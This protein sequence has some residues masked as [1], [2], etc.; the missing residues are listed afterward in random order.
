MDAPGHSIQVLAP[1]DPSGME[2]FVVDGA[3]S[4]LPHTVTLPHA[5]TD[6]IIGFNVSADSVSRPTDLTKKEN[7]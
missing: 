5:V 6:A 1:A 4:T 7:E 2:I 3:P